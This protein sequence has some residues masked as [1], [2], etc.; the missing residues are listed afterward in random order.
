MPI[1]G[2]KSCSIPIFGPISSAEPESDVRMAPGSLVFELNGLFGGGVIFPDDPYWRFA[3]SLFFAKRIYIGPK[4]LI[5]KPW[6]LGAKKR[7]NQYFW[8]ISSCCLYLI[9]S[10]KMS[11]FHIF[12]TRFF[13]KRVVS[14]CY[15]GPN[16]PKNAVIPFLPTFCPRA[17]GVQSPPFS[18]DHPPADYKLVSIQN[19]AHH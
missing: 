17:G 9:F 5:L 2:R 3:K 13:N 16:G 11:L 15:M 7:K 8:P 6:F 12:S 19:P 14:R 4:Y 10:S 1:F 18:Q